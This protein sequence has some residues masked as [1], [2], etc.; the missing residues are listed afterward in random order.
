VR[1]VRSEFKH[2]DFVVRPWTTDQLFGASHFAIEDLEREVKGADFALVVIGPDDKVTS[3]KE[4]SDAPRD[5]VI[6][7]L[8]LFMGQLWRERTFML[9]PRGIDLKIPSDLLELRPLEYAM[10]TRPEDLA[11]VIGP[12]CDELRAIITKVKVR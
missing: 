4:T 10:P 5:N 2:D 8:G 12:A 9:Q 6:F 3:R 11:S 1:A 7:E